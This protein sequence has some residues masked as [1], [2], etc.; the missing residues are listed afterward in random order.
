MPT[1][2]A[3]TLPYRA[4]SHFPAS[5]CKYSPTGTLAGNGSKP[6]SL[7]EAYKNPSSPPT[8]NS[9]PS[10]RTSLPRE[11][12]RPLLEKRRR[13]FHLILRFVGDGLQ[14]RLV[15]QPR[16]QGQLGGGVQ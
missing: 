15:G 2:A 4:S 8:S 10:V 13:A 14:G 5:Y 6:D 7:E 9:S 16:R 12:G 3:R 1:K 11:A